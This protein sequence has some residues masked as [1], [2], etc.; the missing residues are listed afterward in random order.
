[1]LGN[2]HTE[3]LESAWMWYIEWSGDHRSVFAFALIC[4]GW[5]RPELN[6]KEG[7][8]NNTWD[9]ESVFERVENMMRNSSWKD[10]TFEGRR[11]SDWG[12]VEALCTVQFIR[13]RGW[14]EEQR[15]G[16]TEV[17]GYLRNDNTRLGIFRRVE[18]VGRRAVYLWKSLPND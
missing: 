8:A 12:E 2:F 6:P 18:I 13:S 4:H 7:E 5:S 1:M 16:G 9:F 14:L 11:Y 17:I 10:S 3:S 15:T